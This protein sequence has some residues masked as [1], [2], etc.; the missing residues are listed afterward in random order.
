MRPER[1]PDG[2]RVCAARRAEVDRR[3][4]QPG[5]R[6][7][8]RAVVA[9]QCSRPSARPEP[10]QRRG[11]PAAPPR[12][13]RTAPRRR[14]RAVSP[15]PSSPRADRGPLRQRARSTARRKR[16][17]RGPTPSYAAGGRGSRAG[18]ALAGSGHVPRDSPRTCP[19]ATAEGAAA[20][21]PRT[22]MSQ[23]QSPET[24]PRRLRPAE[25][26]ACARV[27]VTGGPLHPDD[28]FRARHDR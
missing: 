21:T 10:R 25:G 1:K 9:R 6:A 13:E 27:R 11:A 15:P 16:A 18:E 12:A 7:P 8:Q 20:N 17:R 19:T 24:C 4:R 23:G 5:G 28:E 2:S 3:D 26:G 14:P 22:A